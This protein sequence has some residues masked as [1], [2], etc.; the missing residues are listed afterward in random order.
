[1]LAA[2]VLSGS[3]SLI[4]GGGSSALQRALDP[5]MVT[6][7][8][9]MLVIGGAT[10]LAG[11]LLRSPSWGVLIERIGLYLLTSAALA[12][13]ATIVIANGKPAIFAGVFV[14]TFGLSCGA[15]AVQITRA[16][17]RAREAEE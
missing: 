15:R 10:A 4:N 8:A 12:Y 17:R 13:G 1:M 9:L 11:V 14:G 2:C 7:W 16:V 6:A 5:W 3:A